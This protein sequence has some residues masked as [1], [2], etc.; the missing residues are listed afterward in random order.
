M[1]DKYKLATERKPNG[2]YAT[3]LTYGGKKINLENPP[4][5]LNPVLCDVILELEENNTRILSHFK[6]V[7]RLETIISGEGLK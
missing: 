1:T 2:E 6:N 3:E 4:Q 7:N 5:P